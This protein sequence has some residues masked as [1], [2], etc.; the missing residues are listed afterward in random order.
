MFCV[1]FALIQ[2][3][4]AVLL[5]CYN[6]VNISLHAHCSLTSFVTLLHSS[7]FYTKLVLCVLLKYIVSD[8]T[9]SPRFSCPKQTCTN[10]CKNADYNH[11]R[12]V[13]LSI[14]AEGVLAEPMTPRHL[15]TRNFA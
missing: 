4:D 14:R 3:E 10:S 13:Y 11:L 2:M 1:H 9:L 15:F 5:I 7:T 12:H 8:C 6:L